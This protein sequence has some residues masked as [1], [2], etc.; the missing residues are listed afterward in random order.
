MQPPMEPPV[1]PG[2]LSRRVAGDEILQLAPHP[3]HRRHVATLLQPP[4]RGISIQVKVTLLP[5]PWGACPSSSQ[6][7][8]LRPILLKS[9]Q[10]A[11]AAY[12]GK[13]GAYGLMADHPW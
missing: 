3:R 7:C 4:G 6:A 12:R 8:L 2:P 13:A 9:N 11:A 10:T 5:S 1:G